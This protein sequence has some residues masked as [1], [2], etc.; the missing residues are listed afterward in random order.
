MKFRLSLVTVSPC[1]DRSRFSQF[2]DND[3][4][5]QYIILQLVFDY[6][7]FIAPTVNA[8]LINYYI[9]SLFLHFIPNVLL[10]SLYRFWI[11]DS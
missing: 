11:V 1:K 9:Y 5:L 7:T 2:N 8:T 4:N 3:R 10:C 6:V